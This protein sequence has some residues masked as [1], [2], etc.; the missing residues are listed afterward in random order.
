MTNALGEI[1]DCHG[2]MKSP[3]AAECG[4]VNWARGAFLD[5]DGE[6]PLRQFMPPH[7]PHAEVE[8]NNPDKTNNR[9]TNQR[10]LFI[11]FCDL[12]C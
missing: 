4:T 3:L 12:H 8:P 11:C 6:S 2:P 5:Q 9:Q 1:N 10:L 7:C